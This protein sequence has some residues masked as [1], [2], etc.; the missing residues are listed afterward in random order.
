MHTTYLIIQHSWEILENMLAILR[1]NFNLMS[2]LFYFFL[3]QFVVD[4][5]SERNNNYEYQQQDPNYNEMNMLTNLIFSNRLEHSTLYQC[6]VYMCAYT[7]LEKYVMSCRCNFFVL[8]AFKQNRLFVK[9]LLAISTERFHPLKAFNYE[10][11]ISA[12][13]VCF[14]ESN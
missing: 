10:G 4:V 2:I 7:K 6:I 9:I 12:G 13:F 5:I 1:P 8:V 3:H 11:I 14:V